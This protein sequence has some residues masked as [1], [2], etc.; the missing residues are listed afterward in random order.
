[1]FAVCVTFQVKSGMMDHFMPLMQ[2]QA[3]NS[4]ANESG[5]HQFD[6]C[7]DEARPDD[8]FLYEL[9][10]DTAAFELHLASEHFKAFDVAVAD[11][12]AD[13]Q[14]NTYQQVLR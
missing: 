13:K 9:Y 4:L 1:M 12:L 2:Q 8:V 11:M 14:V 3:V 6:V 5:C 7:T 10:E